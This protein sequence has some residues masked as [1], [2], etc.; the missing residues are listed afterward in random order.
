MGR[1]FD[2]YPGFQLFFTLGKHFAPECS[3]KGRKI[4]VFLERVLF[5]D[6][7]GYRPSAITGATD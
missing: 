4:K 7:I 1:N 3:I 5:W 2:D 6:K